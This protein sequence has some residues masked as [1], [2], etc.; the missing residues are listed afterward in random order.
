MSQI[1]ANQLAEELLHRSIMA[2]LHAR[3]RVPVGHLELML[4]EECNHRCDYCFVRSKTAARTMTEEI[5]RKA[6][7]LLIRDGARSP[8]SGIL[9]FGGEPLLRFD[10]LISFAAYARQRSQ[11]LRV[12]RGVSL[13]ITTNGTMLTEEMAKLLRDFRI[14]YLLSIDGDKATHDAHRRTVDGRSS[15]DMVRERL[16]TMKQYQPWLGARMTIHPE[17]SDRIR[18]NV[19]H[20]ADL[21]INQFI[22]GPATGLRWSSTA[23]AQY[24]ESLF[25]AL[26]WS[27]MRLLEGAPLRL[28]MLEDD[29]LARPKRYRGQWGCGAGRARISVDVEGNI[30]PCSKVYGVAQ[31]RE[32]YTLGDVWKGMVEYR[33]REEWISGVPDLRH[34]CASCHLADECVG[35]CPATNIEASGSPFVPCLADC[36]IV[37]MGVRLRASWAEF[38]RDHPLPQQQV[39]PQL[40]HVRPLL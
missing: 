37:E 35:G 9:F 5:G 28:G 30:Y 17:N 21:G 15:Y 8:R 10:L 16:A 13:S 26:K 34:K 27:H 25:D 3:N 39:T 38:L 22:I 33:R 29:L 18:N 4:T 24:E 40:R 12:N 2:R 23:L 31:H 36:R 19:E 32:H 6:I 11:D 1:V 14:V 20:L 7:D